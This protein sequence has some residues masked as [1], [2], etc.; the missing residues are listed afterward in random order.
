MQR[1]V[2]KSLPHEMNLSQQVNLTSGE[3]SSRKFTREIQ[4]T[5]DGH[6]KL[7]I[8][9]IPETQPTLDSDSLYP[10]ALCA[11]KLPEQLTL[12]KVQDDECAQS[13]TTRPPSISSPQHCSANLSPNDL[14]ATRPI[15][16][17]PRC[18]EVFKES[19]AKFRTPGMADPTNSYSSLSSRLI[20]NC[21][22]EHVNNAPPVNSLETYQTETGSS[23]TVDDIKISCKEKSH[24]TKCTEST[25]CLESN[26][27]PYEV[28][29]SNAAEG[30][31]LNKDNHASLKTDAKV[32]NQ[33]KDEQQLKRKQ[34]PEAN[35]NVSQCSSSSRKKDLALLTHQKEEE[36]LNLL[37]SLS[38]KLSDKL[39][40]GLP[41]AQAEE[42]VAKFVSILSKLRKI[43]EKEQEKLSS[44]KKGRCRRGESLQAKLTRLEHRQSL[45]KRAE[46]KNA[47]LVKKLAEARRNSV[48]A[49]KSQ[50]LSS[51]ISETCGA[52]TRIPSSSQI[53]ETCGAT[54][55]ITEN[56]D[57]DSATE[58][59]EP[60][61]V[62]V[63]VREDPT[64]FHDYVKPCKKS[65]SLFCPSKKIAKNQSNIPYTD[66]SQ[67]EGLNAS[68]ITNQ[69][70]MTGNE[71]CKEVSKAESVLDQNM[72]CLA[73]DRNVEKLT[74]DK[75]EK[76]NGGTK[77]GNNKN[78]ASCNEQVEQLNS[79]LANTL[80]QHPLIITNN[81]STK[82]EH[83]QFQTANKQSINE[84]KSTFNENSTAN[85]NPS[86]NL[87][88]D[89]LSPA[90]HL[91]AVS[92][93][94]K[95]P[96]ED[97]REA[98]KITAQHFKIDH[99]C[100]K[101]NSLDNYS[102][103]K[104]KKNKATAD[105]LLQDL[106]SPKS[107]FKTN[108]NFVKTNG[109]NTDRARI[110]K[111]ST[112]FTA[113]DRL[114]SPEAKTS[115]LS[116]IP[117]C[118]KDNATSESSIRPII[119]LQGYESLAS[120]SKETNTLSVNT[121]PEVNS[122]HTQIP[123][124]IPDHDS[125][126]KINCTSGSI[127]F[128]TKASA[129]WLQKPPHEAVKL[130]RCY[131]TSKREQRITVAQAARQQ[132]SPP[133]VFTSPS[134]HNH[135]N[136]TGLAMNTH[137]PSDSTESK[138]NPASPC[139]T[140]SSCLFTIPLSLKLKNM[141]Q[142]GPSFDQNQQGKGLESS[143]ISNNS[144]K[145]FSVHTAISSTL[146]APHPSRLI[147]GSNLCPDN[148]TIQ[149]LT[150]T[151]ASQQSTPCE[152]LTQNSSTITTSCNRS[153]IFSFQSETRNLE[154][155]NRLKNPVFADKSFLN[156]S[157]S[158]PRQ[159]AGCSAM[160]TS[161][162]EHRISKEKCGETKKRKK[163]QRDTQTYNLPTGKLNASSKSQ[164]NKHVGKTT[165]KIN[166]TTKGRK[167]TGKKTTN[168]TLVS[169][170][171]I[172]DYFPK[173]SAICCTD[174]LPAQETGPIST[175]VPSTATTQSSP[176]DRVPS[177]AHNKNNFSPGLVQHGPAS[178]FKYARVEDISKENHC[179]L[180]GSPS[181]NPKNFEFEQ[182]IAVRRSENSRPLMKFETVHL[183]NDDELSVGG[184]DM[185]VFWLENFSDMRMT[186]E[187]WFTVD[188][189]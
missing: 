104:H 23:G 7:A 94:A 127:P 99:P 185:E 88:E 184:T 124:A 47:I 4:R 60:P 30:V 164:Q 75:T 112:A 172:G 82:P 161:C 70:T 187:F 141:A 22:A 183:I 143:F 147:T 53:S 152:Q 66:S 160:D 111:S 188:A 125:S 186:E 170:G 69:Q 118:L 55:H 173:L 17:N 174:A 81:E 162:T 44:S 29:S 87:E 84:N 40:C 140:I 76:E 115:T 25:K 15:E 144:P 101:Q 145:N 130:T 133:L 64:E 34:S 56:K 61:K 108:V 149:P 178:N 33:S 109:C 54:T 132:S 90:D 14:H 19:N 157:T 35:V 135:M 13:S 163:V 86:E 155:S 52:T 91:T 105:Q 51:Q 18:S 159:N 171:H 148:I 24:K 42:Q 168:S 31:K 121:L 92:D 74:L 2:E 96:K 72:I 1:C 46:F 39:D 37:I 176:S 180:G 68:Y 71:K 43:Q 138:A 119:S 93:S 114:S 85:C 169:Q 38:T 189:W 134:T 182:I 110:K 116:Q 65:K 49:S 120:S 10:P 175:L 106:K 58:V 102:L 150:S 153:E 128:Q 16:E 179:F 89:T 11:K 156:D 26:L 5:C 158:T 177:A 129:T 27:Q 73:I 79:Y 165:S 80:V 146:P 77:K 131:E 97:N 57:F 6:T 3:C 117:V 83:Q 50:S 59:T 12:F 137:Q 45:L 78:F 167:G 166:M 151:Y 154:N 8:A 100:L 20:L 62:M 122:M 139:S 181:V 95:Q 36:S 21:D 48:S 63:P 41:H 9:S 32:H 98:N 107:I 142:G 113:S 126:P 103:P 136:S 123:A 67:S 28:K